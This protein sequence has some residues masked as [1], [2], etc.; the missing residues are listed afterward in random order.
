MV[1]GT[2]GPKELDAKELNQLLRFGAYQLFNT[3]TN[4]AQATDKRIMDESLDSILARAS[5]VQYLDAGGHGD[6]RSM[7]THRHTHTIHTHIHSTH[8]TAI[9]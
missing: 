9:D 7:D 3:D 5:R 4:T 6:V 8:L 2:D 1:D